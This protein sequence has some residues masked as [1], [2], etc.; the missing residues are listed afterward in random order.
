MRAD[1]RQFICD[2]FVVEDGDFADDD[3]FLAKNILDSTGILELV[4]FLE[5]KYGIKVADEELT[6]VNL[7]SVNKLC[8]FLERKLAAGKSGR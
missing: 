1:V 6:P 5:A 4:S 3:S 2:N 7:D 8:G